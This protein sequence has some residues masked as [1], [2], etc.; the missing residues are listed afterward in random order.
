MEELPEELATSPGDPAMKQGVSQPAKRSAGDA[1]GVDS[2]NRAGKVQPVKTNMVINN[3]KA[4]PRNLFIPTTFLIINRIHYKIIQP[5]SPK[6][7]S[8]I[9]PLH[10]SI[11]LQY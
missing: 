4:I 5:G 1:V 3:I 8:S 10:F 9:S 11:R 7:G 2:T 6:T